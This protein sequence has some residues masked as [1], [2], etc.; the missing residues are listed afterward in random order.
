MTNTAIVEA[1]LWAVVLAP[2][3][4]ALVGVEV[5]VTRECW[6]GGRNWPGWT[7]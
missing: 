3:V 1:V 2:A 5:A 6:I 7:R 4:L